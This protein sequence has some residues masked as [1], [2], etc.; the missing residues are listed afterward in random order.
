MDGSSV[1]SPLFPGP[2]HPG[3]KIPISLGGLL[4][5]PLQPYTLDAA[6]CHLSRSQ[7]AS[8]GRLQGHLGLCPGLP[9]ISEQES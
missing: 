1:P 2:E 4:N 8:G 5:F 3:G 7:T 6:L 9:V